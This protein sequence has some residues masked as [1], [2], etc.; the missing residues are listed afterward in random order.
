MGAKTTRRA[1]VLIREFA[2]RTTMRPA[3]GGRPLQEQMSIWN[4]E[5]DSQ[6]DFVEAARIFSALRWKGIAI[7]PGDC[8]IA[9]PAKR[10]DLLL[11][12]HDPDFDSIPHPAR[13][14]T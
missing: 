14:G 3:D 13:Y 4:Y 2:L 12:T 11:R 9:A 7:P 1:N 5:P 10:L 8:L 6:N